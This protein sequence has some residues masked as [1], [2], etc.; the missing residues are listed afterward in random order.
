MLL[1]RRV[2][3]YCR[4]QW[5]IGDEGERVCVGSTLQ[6]LTKDRAPGNENSTGLGV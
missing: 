5:I 2:G 3:I 1:L 4:L 6:K